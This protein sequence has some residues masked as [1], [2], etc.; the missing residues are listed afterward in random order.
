M[1]KDEAQAIL[2]DQ[3]KSF[4]ARSYSELTALIDKPIDVEIAGLSGTKY[5]IE[6]NVFFTANQVGIY[7][8]LV[9]SMTVD[10]KHLFHFPIV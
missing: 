10:G 7:I 3:L 8:S 4:T 1:N 6:V 5:Q 2:S 9:L